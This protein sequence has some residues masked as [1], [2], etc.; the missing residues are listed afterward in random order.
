MSDISIVDEK[1]H[2]TRFI[3]KYIFVT[4]LVNNKTHTFRGICLEV[5]DDKIILDDHKDGPIPLSFDFLSVTGVKEEN[6]K[7]Y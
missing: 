5:L 4:K 1:K 7:N 3:G 2:W 6:G